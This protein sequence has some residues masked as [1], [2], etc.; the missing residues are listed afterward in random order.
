MEAS[1]SQQDIQSF[2]AGTLWGDEPHALRRRT[3]RF[4][5]RVGHFRPLRIIGGVPKLPLSQQVRCFYLGHRLLEW[6][7]P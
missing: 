3:A 7:T 6:P 2:I 5:H 1:H 4:D